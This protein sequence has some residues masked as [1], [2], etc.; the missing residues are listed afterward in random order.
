MQID[1]IEAPPGVKL[2]EWEDAPSKRN[3]I[4]DG[5][6]KSL[7][8]KFPKSYGGLRLELHNLRYEGPEN[9]SLKEQKAALMDNRFLHRKLKG[10]IKLFDEATGQKLDERDQT[11]MRVPTLTERHT[12]EH[13]GTEYSLISQARL[14]PGVYTRRKGNG[15]I[16]SHFNARRSTGHSFRIRL[17]PESGL[18]KM[19][20]GQSSLRL[21]SLLHDL[22]IPDEDLEKRW[23]PELLKKNKAAYDVRVFDKAFS[24]MVKRPDPTLDRAGKIKAILGA[25]SDTKLDAEV[26]MHT[27]PQRMQSFRKSATPVNSVSQVSQ[28]KLGPHIIPTPVP[29]MLGS[30]TFNQDT[31]TDQE[32]S[33][34]RFNRSDYLLLAQLLNEKFQAGIP[35]NQPLD[36]LADMLEAKLK[37]LMPD[38]NPELLEQLIK[39][40]T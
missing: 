20:V 3:A 37:A 21:Y 31:T 39:S 40:N 38:D 36:Q 28:M 10:T 2:T 27:L 12:F 19:D 23:G 35:L 6:Q 15:E 18:F 25:L 34:H 30:R 4:Y 5:V 7:A 22:G 26:L 8:S 17:E 29:D 13:S 32:A 16:E 9:Y 24:R 14:M 11:L 1:D 33:G